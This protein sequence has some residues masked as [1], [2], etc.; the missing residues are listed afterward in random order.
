MQK[1][2]WKEKN[3]LAKKTFSNKVDKVYLVKKDMIFPAQPGHGLAGNR[4]DDQAS[5][6]RYAEAIESF[7]GDGMSI[8]AVKTER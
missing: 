3:G 7:D 6:R 5:G 1:Y 2:E 4:T 8:V